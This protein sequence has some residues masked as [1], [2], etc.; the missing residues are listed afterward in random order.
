MAR[1]NRR[2]LKRTKLV[3]NKKLN[4]VELLPVAL[5]FRI[6]LAEDVIKITLHA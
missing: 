1:R 3:F 2:L 5:S 4:Q 6:I